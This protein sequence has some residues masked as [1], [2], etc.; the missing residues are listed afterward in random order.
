MKKSTLY[1]TFIFCLLL[2][3]SVP[4]AAQISQG[5]TPPS[6][7]YSVTNRFQHR[8]LQAPDMEIIHNEDMLNQAAGEPGPRR[9]GVSV[10]VN[11]GIE[12]SGTWTKLPNGGKIW[13]LELQAK[14]ALALGVYYDDFFIPNGGKLFLYNDNRNQVIGAFTANNNPQEHLFSTQFVQGDKVVLEYYQPQTVTQTARIHISELAYAYRDIDFM[15]R[16]DRSAWA[17]M[18]DVACSE[19]DNWQNQIKGV[20]RISIKIGGNYY[21]CSGTL[22]NNTNNDRTPYFLTASHCGGNASA[23]DLNQWIFYFNYQASTCNGSASGYNSTTG[24]QMKAHDPSHADAGSDFYLVEFNNAIPNIFNVFYNG[25]NRTD[26][27]ADAGNGVGIHHPAGDIKKIST[28]D[29]PI[30]SS[31]FWNGLPTHWR[32]T[33]AYTANGRSIMQPGSSGSP[34]FDSNGLIMGDLTGGYTSNSCSNP[35]PAFYGKIWYSW[36]QNGNTPSTRLKDWLDSGNTGIEKLPGIS[37]QVIPPVADF[38]AD[39]TTV[40][41]GDTVFFTDLSQPG[42]LTWDWSFQNGNPDSANIQNPYSVYA[43]TGTYDVSLT[44]TNADGSDTEIKTSYIHVLPMALPVADFDADKT[45]IAPGD[46]VHFTDLSSGNPYA[47]SWQFDGGSPT[48]STLQN[49]IVRYSTVGIYPV[50]LVVYNLGGA[51]SLIRNDYITVT[52]D[53][54]VADFEA[55]S[56][57]IMEGDSVNFTDL[58]TG[59]PTTWY[60]SFP[61]ATPDTSNEQNPQ[62]I[63]YAQGGNYT[64]SLTVANGVG[65]NTVTK[66]DYMHVDY[67][68]IHEKENPKEFQIYPNPGHGIFT[69]TLN[70]TSKYPL[71]TEVLNSKGEAIFHAE[72]KKNNRHITINLSNQKAGVYFV[73]LKQGKKESKQKLTLIK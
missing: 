34:V 11:K 71:F 54:P 33:W 6:F 68:G 26:S 35:S 8:T 7:Q 65:E 48:S 17:C 40:T 62:N 55:S 3:F 15:I 37:W 43:D 16:K 59:T 51:D 36:D 13:R 20:A 18:I 67:V 10:Y 63:V 12:N 32:L 66:E 31:T 56:T 19:G 46:K 25:W 53:L 39:T 1:F 47:W 2:G 23:S 41:Q 60:W 69:L 30:T 50:K 4:V 45:V 27:N 72:Y 38:S 49:P 42:I 70:K 14:G 5:G 61:G 24:C 58:S 29:T 9:M 57:S 52:N 73:I 44:V 64:V 28:Y 22:I 21:W